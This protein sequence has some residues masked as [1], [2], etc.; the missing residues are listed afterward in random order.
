MQ[1]CDP[2]TCTKSQATEL[3]GKLHDGNFSIVEF[4]PFS[5]RY[6]WRNP[7]GNPCIGDLVNDDVYEGDDLCTMTLVEPLL[8]QDV[9]VTIRSHLNN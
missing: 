4:I 9:D 3:I 5:Y 1:G 2:I 8:G 6:F 7:Y